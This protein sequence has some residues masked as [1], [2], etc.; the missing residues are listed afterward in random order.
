MHTLCRNDTVPS[1]WYD[2][3]PRKRVLGLLKGGL[4]EGRIK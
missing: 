2:E 4:E 1:L 3:T